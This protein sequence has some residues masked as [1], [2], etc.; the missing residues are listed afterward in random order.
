MIINLQDVRDLRKRFPQVWLIK[1]AGIVV[2]VGMRNVF[3]VAG[4]PLDILLVLA[5][6][7]GKPLLEKRHFF[8]ESIT[9]NLV[10][11]AQLDVEATA[12]DVLLEDILPHESDSAKLGTL[13]L[14]CSG[15]EIIAR[16]CDETPTR[17]LTSSDNKLVAGAA[18]MGRDSVCPSFGTSFRHGELNI[19]LVK[20]PPLV[21][22][23]GTR[24]KLSGIG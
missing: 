20:L 7:H 8:P 19:I 6:A 11:Q 17:F 21:R 4:C 14:R 1:V 16:V 24:L 5:A 12:F 3:L 18:Q 23:N 9:V 13:V 22:E 10:S 15:G 2:E